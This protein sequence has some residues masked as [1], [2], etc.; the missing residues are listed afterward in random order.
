MEILLT[1]ALMY[2]LTFAFKDAKLLNRPRKWLA[3][4]DSFKELLSCA[5]CT[6]FH[7]G[8]M[9]FLLLKSADISPLPWLQGLV[10][11][12]FVGAAVSYVLD[13]VLLHFESDD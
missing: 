13:V 6:G 3:R 11:Y 10:I 12:A 5:Y 9:A 1:V 8:W 4:L 7:T 2:G